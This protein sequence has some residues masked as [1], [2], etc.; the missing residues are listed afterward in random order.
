[1]Q[2]CICGEKINC[3]IGFGYVCE[4]GKRWQ[5]NHTKQVYELI[6][7]DVEA[8]NLDK[9]AEKIEKK[10]VSNLIRNTRDID[11]NVVEAVNEHFWNLI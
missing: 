4:C 10:F 3:S 6:N 1:M 9:T 5:W 11:I 7:I 8:E 2:Y